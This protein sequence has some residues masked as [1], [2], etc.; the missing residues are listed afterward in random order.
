MG[1]YTPALNL[2]KPTINGVETANNWGVDINANFD[3]IDDWVGPLPDRI[4][5]LETTGGPPGPQG[6]VGPQGPQGPKGDPGAPGATGAQGPIGLTGPQGPKGDPGAAGA[7]ST[8]PGP[9]GPKGDPG[10]AGA[11]STV[12]GPQGP[13]GATGPQGPPGATGP[14][15]PQGPAGSS[16]TVSDG[17]KGDIIVSGSGSSLMLDSGVVTTAARTLLDDVSIAAML[18]T[19]GAAPLA[20]PIFTGDPQ[21]PTPTAGDNDTSIATTAFVQAAVGALVS[22]GATWDAA[23]KSARITLTNGNLT[24][25]HDTVNGYGVAQA[26]APKSSGKFYYEYQILAGLNANHQ[27]GFVA[28]G[29]INSNY[30]SW[31]FNRGIGYTPS[32][33]DVSVRDVSIGTAAAAALNAVVGVAIDITAN[34]VWFRVGAGNWNNNASANPATGVGGFTIPGSIA[35]PYSPA[36]SGF[37]GEKNTVNFGATAYASPAPAGFGNWSASPPSTLDTLAELAAALGNDPNALA[38]KAPLASPVFTGDPQAPTPA[39][40]D[41]DTS[42]AT[43]AFVQ[44][45]IASG[46]SVVPAGCCRLNYINTTTIRLNPYNGNRLFIN[47]KNEVIPSAGVTLASTGLAAGTTYN[48]YTFMA[49]STMTLE[50]STTARATSPLGGHQIKSGDETRTLVGK[51]R[52]AGAA[53]FAYDARDILVINWFNRKSAAG[54]ASLAANY[55]MGASPFIVLP[56]LTIYFLAWGDEAVQ[57]AFVATAQNASA[58]TNFFGIGADG[59]WEIFTYFGGTDNNS[60]TVSWLKTPPEG[61]VTLQSGSGI[62]GGGPLVIAAGGYTT[63]Q[64]VC[65]A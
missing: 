59:V 50:A 22:A 10:A 17:D 61:L 40:S 33:G 56:D 60:A 44:S 65:P 13:A 3:K 51:I 36:W 23:T 28:S 7:D 38:L 55:S 64:L 5:A 24:G 43:T 54:Y 27:L 57:A 45:A 12:P 26:T 4:E 19:L 58:A 52:T 35:T 37:Y 30:L 31:N 29:W 15:G 14:Q 34:R 46:L 53:Q 8:V 11:D 20:S 25:E 16:G 62:S 42:I 6:P 39:A 32:S 18:A 2:S 49:G 21:A 9:Q 1:T 63:T 41:N 47:G 48:I